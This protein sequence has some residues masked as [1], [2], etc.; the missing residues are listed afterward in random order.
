MRAY[1]VAALLFLATCSA[2]QHRSAVPQG[3]AANMQLPVAVAKRPPIQ[4]TAGDGAGLELRSLRARAVLLGPL[5]FTEAELSFHNPQHRIRE[6]QLALTL[7]EG[8]VV[9]R[10]AMRNGGGWLEG[11][12]VAR[13][14]ARQ[15]YEDFV[16]R[17]QDPA[18]L[19][20]DTGNVFRARVFPIPAHA[21]VDLVVSWSQEL[22]D[23]QTA[24]TLPL[25]GLPKLPELSVHVYLNDAA[26]PA[27]ATPGAV[28][29]QIRTVALDRSNFQPDQDFRVVA[30]DLP[31]ARA[32][33]RHGRIALARVVVPGA[34]EPASF[35]KLAI[36]LDTSASQ[37]A[38]FGAAVEAV[39]AIA[40]LAAQRGASD[41]RVIAFDQE[42]Q[43]LY[44][45]PP[46]QL[47]AQALQQ[48]P[49]LGASNLER[50]LQA[51][52]SDCSRAVVV[53]DGLVTAGVREPA[54]LVA[55]LRARGGGGLR[56]LDAVV[57]GSAK[58]SRLLQALAAKALPEAG[59]V[60]AADEG[61]LELAA[62]ARAPYGRTRIRV[63]GA[64]WVWPEYIDGLQPGKT[65]T[66][67]ADLPAEDPLV[68]ELA[69]AVSETMRPQA[70]D[71]PGPLLERAV[72]A[73]RI[74]L[75]LDRADQ[76]D[77]PQGNALRQ[78][79]VDLSVRH[80]VLCPETALLVLASEADY[81]RYRLDRRAL[82]DILT[83]APEGVVVARKRGEADPGAVVPPDGPPT[84]P[85]EW[86]ANPG[87][88]DSS[89]APAP[90]PPKEATSP[91][92]ERS[93]FYDFSDQLIDGDIKKPT[94]LY[95][96]SHSRLR[97]ARKGERDHEDEV[98]GENAATTPQ[99]AASIRAERARA[100]ALTGT[101]A[102]IEVLRTSGKP[103][104]ALQKAREWQAAEPGE[105]LPYVALALALHANGQDAEAA[106]AAGS[107][108]DL[109]SGRADIRRF[110]GNLLD[111]LGPSGN[112]LARDTYQVAV[113]DRGDQPGGYHMLA[114]ALARDGKYPEA[115]DVLIRGLEHQRRAGSFAE[116]DR[117]LREDLGILAAVW[118]TRHPDQLD[119]L[120]KRLAAV[121]AVP[122]K[123]PSL[124]FV[125]SW[126]TDAN[127]MDLHVFDG[128]GHEAWYPSRALASGGSLL[129]DVQTGLG[130][131]CFVVENPQA[132]PYYLQVHYY[133]RGAMGHGLGRVQVLR[134]DGKGNLAVEERPFVIMT[135]QA[136]I[137]LGSVGR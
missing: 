14:Q 67:I 21:D 95:V 63:P 27:R 68:I 20:Q 93:K 130:P 53:S 37:H 85:P 115:M 106:R 117:V 129:A 1:L 4:L 61:R 114:L 7:P 122:A 90:P 36:L 22:T 24:Y 116:V 131:E 97:P 19:E 42:V 110:A 66:V 69:G 135:D 74:Q 29:S 101:F 47:S 5:A 137:D 109:N 107:L 51:I 32:A 64:T 25:A 77:G 10:F 30:E 128:A 39:Q 18:L 121:N 34:A 82:A 86:L 54:A 57:L 83:V 136:W 132:F 11:E 102:A 38:S 73:A 125:L 8:A 15:I 56:R 35:G 58:N 2:G 71:A 40:K 111:S 134:Y 55:R 108:V 12:V 126:E 84:P 87:R 17:R 70:A 43:T 112:D 26:V 13:Q 133:N 80:R 50:A 41:L 118:L 23:A 94:Q 98:A 31:D 48:R 78:E 28:A 44:S 127:D 103:K 113:A 33:L 100:P 59:A 119:Q 72:M 88:E 89:A 46:G 6:G 60:L 81:V 99:V 75:L 62:L 16:H 120:Q 79:A 76:L 123:G 49:P 9:S 104:E 124:R 52:P 65:M 105:L 92:S 96:E 91:R 45:G 3:K